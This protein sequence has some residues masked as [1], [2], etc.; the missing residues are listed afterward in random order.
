MN[1]DLEPALRCDRMGIRLGQALVFVLQGT[2]PCGQFVEEVD[3][4]L[5]AI[6]PW[7]LNLSLRVTYD[8]GTEHLKHGRHNIYS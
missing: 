5:H 6:S 7:E 8:M 4:G 1:F 2:V 3:V